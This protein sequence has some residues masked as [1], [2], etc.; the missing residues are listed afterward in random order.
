MSNESNDNF[1]EVLKAL[2]ECYYKDRKYDSEVNF[3]KWEGGEITAENLWVVKGVVEPTENKDWWD[4]YKLT[5]G[6]EKYQKIIK[7]NKENA[8]NSFYYYLAYKNTAIVKPLG[9]SLSQAGYGL[10]SCIDIQ[11]GQNEPIIENVYKYYN[12]TEPICTKSEFENYSDTEND[13]INNIKAIL[14]DINDI[15]YPKEDED[16]EKIF[17]RVEDNAKIPNAL[18]HKLMMVKMLEIYDKKNKENNKENNSINLLFIADGDV[19]N[20]YYKKYVKGNQTT[21]VKQNIEL[22]QTIAGII[23]DI[24][25]NNI[26]Y[27]NIRRMSSLLWDY[28]HRN[29]LFKEIGDDK[30]KQIIYTGAPGTGKTYG[31]RSYVEYLCKLDPIENKTSITGD[32]IEQYK[33]V[34]FHSTYD[35][36]DFVE[37]LRPARLNADANDTTFVRMDGVFKNFCRDVVAYNEQSKNTDKK[38]Y[39]IIDEIN[40]ADL[41]KVFGELM[42]ALEESYRGQEHRVDTQYRNLPTYYYDK[43]E[44]EFKE[45]TNDCFK[46]GFYI[47]ENVYIIGS[48]NDIDRS[49][50]TFDFALRRR[51]KWININANAVMKQTLKEMFRNC[52]WYYNDISNGDTQIDKLTEK[53]QALNRVI[54][55]EDTGGEY[56]G[57][58]FRLNDAYQIGPAYFKD[59][60]GTE[61]KTETKTETEESLKK[62]WAEKVEP[63][64]RE[65]VRGYE[66]AE[67]DGFV[68]L[69]KEQLIDGE[70]EETTKNED[71]FEEIKDDK[72][73]Q[74]IYTGAPGT[75]KTYGIRSYVE[76]L[77]KLDPIEN[78]TS[79]TGDEIEQ[80]KF[81]QFHSTYDYSDFVEGLR[82]A[83]LNADA[84]DTT[85]V[86]MDGVFKNF[87]RDVVAY[88]EQSKNTDKKFYFIIDE[89]NRADLG[90][91]FGELMYALEESYRGQEHRVDTQYRNLPTYYYDKTEKEFKEI[92]NDCFKDGFYIP[93]N[94][95]IIGSMNDIDRSVETFDFALRRRFKW[96]NINANAVMKQT[97]KEMFRNCD[98][99]Y[100]D[101]SNG[102]T[103]IDKLTEK[104]Q[105]LNR[106]ISGE[107]TGGEYNGSRFRLNDAY[108]IGPAY[109]R[110]YDGT[111]ESLEKIWA[112]KVEPILRE[113]VRGYDKTEIEEFVNLC[114]SKLI[115]NDEGDI[116]SDSK[117]ETQSEEESQ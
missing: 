54:S 3:E 87:C 115:N 82:P 21:W 1:E 106:V 41:G 45:I 43:T 97:L 44:K 14:K 72:C 68:N 113:Y 17:T 73:K 103:Q 39:F 83:R 63:I 102:D 38:F 114:K 11:Q 51:F 105:A 2:W 5:E 74:I 104:I 40:R 37:G 85:F 65:Y 70:I 12:G 30:C 29:E 33:F 15:M 61:T 24:D 31:I 112:E 8:E 22:T 86:R 66:K 88:N 4:K 99:Y 94:V 116:T 76:Y 84:N 108:Q 34:Q 98:W 28:E 55:G 81:V 7:E 77:C 16:L 6:K 50:E 47:P 64:L 67:I 53:I 18:R 20:D 100:N 57:S 92:T 78:K 95:Y 10:K 101:I 96:I 90:K 48:M 35:Y 59:F 91:V 109:F 71:V 110:Y 58:R 25:K 89:I 79:I 117:K 27:E 107:D 60:K 19:I 62:I 46:D 80:Y 111:E 26:E 36:S 56:N 69:C 13:D 32:E 93:E 52:D 75:G 9:Q 49:V 42:Y 23:D